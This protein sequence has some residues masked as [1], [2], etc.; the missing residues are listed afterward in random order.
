MSVEFARRFL[1]RGWKFIEKHGLVEKD[2]RIFI[3]LSGGKDS[4]TAAYLLKSY[5]DEKNLDCEL[6]ALHLNLNFEVSEE[7]ERIVKKQAS[8]FGFKLIKVNVK[9]YGIDLVKISKK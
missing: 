3:A 6:I 9:D 1:K 8:K 5:V 4:L 2:D 7:V